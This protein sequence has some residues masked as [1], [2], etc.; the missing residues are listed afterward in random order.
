MRKAFIKRFCFYKKVFS[1]YKKVFS[2]YKKGFS[3]LF[4]KKIT[5]IEN[6]KE[7]NSY[8]NLNKF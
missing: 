5:N 8:K 4:F 7:S 6:K 1:F 2:F 3:F